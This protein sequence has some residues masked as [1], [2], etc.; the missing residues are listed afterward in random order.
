[1]AILAINLEEVEVPPSLDAKITVA[2]VSDRRACR[3]V[4]EPAFRYCA[5]RK[6][7]RWFPLFDASRTLGEVRTVDS[8][9]IS[10]PLLANGQSVGRALQ[11]LRQLADA[12]PILNWSSGLRA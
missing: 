10:G 7:S 12:R 4:D 2:K 5:D 8:R 3:S 11:S 9:G 1:M 6:S